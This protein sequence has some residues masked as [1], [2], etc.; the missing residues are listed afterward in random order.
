VLGGLHHEYSLGSTP[1]SHRE[2]HGPLNRMTEDAEV[3]KSGV[4]PA[5]R[6]FCGARAVRSLGVT[7]HLEPTT[8]QLFAFGQRRPVLLNARA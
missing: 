8:A 7:H 2:L 3:L 1:G 5:G 6:H 4:A